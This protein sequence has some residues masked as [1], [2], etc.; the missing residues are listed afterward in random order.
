M[1]IGNRFY[2]NIRNRKEPK[3]KRDS[4]NVRTEKGSQRLIF[5]HLSH[6]TYKYT[7]TQKDETPVPTWLRTGQDCC[8]RLP[9]LAKLSLQYTK[10]SRIC[11]QC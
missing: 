7:R 4:W 10:I 3:N 11:I 8:S 5:T 6:L 9:P 1:R 2:H